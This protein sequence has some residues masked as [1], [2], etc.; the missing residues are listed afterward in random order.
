[1][2]KNMKQKYRIYRRNQ[3]GNYYIQD[4]VTGKQASLGTSDKGAS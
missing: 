1:M 3:N 2:R 4:N